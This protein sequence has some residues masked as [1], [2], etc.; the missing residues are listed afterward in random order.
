MAH[1]QLIRTKKIFEAPRLVVSRRL[2]RRPDKHDP[3]REYQLLY[4]D[5]H[6]IELPH[7]V[8]FSGGRSSGMLLFT[9]LEN[10]IL[11]PDRGD[12]IVF[13]NTSCEHP[14]TYD[15]VRACRTASKS[16]GIPFF[17]VEFQTYEDARLG[18]WT[19]L[20]TYRLANG[21]P[22][23]EENPNGFHW[24]G[25][26]FEELMSWSGYV[27]NQFRRICTVNMKLEATRHFLKDWLAC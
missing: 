12:V 15:F 6:H 13:N 26:V 25:E 3:S 10:G 1:S 21:L 5:R 17:L 11:D 16:Y 20:P 8:K 9:L 2:R 4:Q 18:T 23:S 19:R 27:P 7:V 24:R 14:Y 22:W